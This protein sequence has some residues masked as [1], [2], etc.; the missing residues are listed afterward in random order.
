[1]R[2]FLKSKTPPATT[3]IPIS[4]RRGRVLRF[5]YGNLTPFSLKYFRAPG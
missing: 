2:V 4:A 5:T 1:M 3:R